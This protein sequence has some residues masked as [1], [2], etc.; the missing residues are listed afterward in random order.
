MKDRQTINKGRLLVLLLA[1]FVFAASW[2]WTPIYA[3]VPAQG[4]NSLVELTNEERAFLNG[5][6]VRIGV[7]SDRAPYEFL[8]HDG[9]Y[10]GISADFIKVCAQ[11]LGI[12]LVIVPGLSVSAAIKKL[13][14]GEIDV[15][16]KIADEPD[17]REYIQFTKA[18][19]SS[20]AVIV[21]RQNTRDIGGVG[22]LKGLRVGVCRGQLVET[23]MKR[24]YPD[25][26][27]EILPDVHNALVDLA[28][29][30]VDAYIENMSMVGYNI[31]KLGLTTLKI[32]AQSP[33]TYDVAFGVRKD[34][35][36]LASALDKALLGMSKEE[37][38]AIMSHWLTVEYHNKINWRVYGP[39]AASLFIITV[40]VII[41]NRRLRRV[42][43][44]L[45]LTRQE[46][47]AANEKTEAWTE[48]LSIA[49]E[50]AVEASIAKSVFIANMSHEI[51]TPMN[52]IVGFLDLVAEDASITSKNR[53]YIE[54][55]IKSAKSLLR[56]INDILDISKLESGKIEIESH[57]FSIYKLIE[58]VKNSFEQQIR[59]NGLYFK[60]TLDSGLPSEYYLGDSARLTQVII[61]LIGNAIKFTEHGGITL[62][63]NQR[64]EDGTMLFSIVDTGLGIPE[65]RQDKIF[66]AFT[67]ADSSTTRRF[68]GTGLGTTISRQLV[69]L[70]GG[71]IWLESELNKGSVFSFTVKLTPTQQTVNE[72][73]EDTHVCKLQK[74]LRILVAE[75]VEENILLLKTRLEQR[76]HRIETA[77]NGYEAVECYKR[78][79]FDIILMDMQMPVMDGLEATR[80][81]REIESNTGTHIPIIALTASVTSDERKIYISKSVDEVAAK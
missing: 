29:G 80:Q 18:Y 49:K 73:I 79:G 62:T 27:L 13:Q 10:S 25:L 26:P 54:I 14:D 39:I 9:V 33:Y 19:A 45:E 47:M 77:R 48:E 44:K 31:D 71:R 69:E 61:N 22:D 3:D 2:V 11:R 43:H 35:P 41:W 81:I 7:D 36:L 52:S 76:G 12:Q 37:K 58:G 53:E 57:P 50:A 30:K 59:Q 55:A 28:A 72:E 34:W 38:S 15:I 16:T 51:R 8:D 1:L 21:T 56:L 64:D 65:D 24:D 20:V 75:D 42:V 5:R 23:F 4:A 32:A 40:F 70:M 78:D 46:L 6:Q 66:E 67:Q 60:I 68:G 17:R 63:V 74:I